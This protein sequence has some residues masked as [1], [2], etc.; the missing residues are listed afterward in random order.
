MK[1]SHKL[2][3]AFIAIYSL[4]T[5]VGLITL[6]LNNN[7]KNPINLIIN[8]DLKENKAH[9]EFNN[10]LQK[11]RFQLIKIWQFKVE[12]K[13]IYHEK[14]EINQTLNKLL[15]RLDIQLAL[16]KRILQDL[17]SESAKN[18]INIHKIESL[19]PE[20]ARILEVKPNLARY[21]PTIDRYFQLLD[22]NKIHEASLLLSTEI[23]PY[24]NQKLDGSLQQDSESSL[25]E[26]TEKVSLVFKE[27]K[28]DDWTIYV[29]ILIALLISLILN[30][31][32]SESITKPIDKLKEAALQVGK[33]NF[34]YQIPVKP[35]NENNEIA[36]LASCFN[37]MMEGL[38]KTTVSKFYLGKILD[39]MIDSLVV[40]D[41]EGNIQIV[42]QATCKL[43]NYSTNELVGKKLSVILKESSLSLSQFCLQPSLDNYETKY[44][45]KSRVK[46]PILFSSS[47]IYNKTNYPCGIV[48]I[49]RDIT[50]KYAAEK[51]LKT[52]EE[53]YAL[54]SL[55]MDEG[56]WD[57]NLDSN[58]IYYSP[59]WKNLLGYEDSE[60]IATSQEWFSRVHRQDLEK[61]NRAIKSK[62]SQFE[63][64]YRILHKDFK[65]RFM[66]CRGIKI[67]NEAGNVYRIAGSQRDITQTN[68]A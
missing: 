12:N 24:L 57:W 41:L 53:R 5:G 51:K 16:H 37:I 47:F 66:L 32:L 27:V 11:F 21:R 55:A 10:T 9:I 34:N 43:L 39:S 59:R 15:N 2:T 8:N 29:S 33:G 58:E 18:H 19:K 48:C 40:T 45:T 67:K 46:I 17:E 56:L 38:K 35:N 13:P 49:A 63:I 42:N 22:E 1:I 62:D 6:S 28:H 54:A 14:Q 7:V 52:S 68:V 25:N 26:L 3:G 60:I 4:L 64:T 31:Y 44:S 36:Q 30:K 50:E 65:Y 20:I 61:I 23:E